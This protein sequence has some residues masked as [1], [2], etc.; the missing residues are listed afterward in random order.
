[1]TTRE[2]ILLSPYRLPTHS[3]LYL[4]DEEVA[5]FLNGYTALWHPAA[6]LGAASPPRVGSP[7][8]YE[9]PAAGHVYAVPDN[10]P[11]MLPDDWEERVRA[12]G[13]RLFRCTTDRAATLANLAE[14]L[15]NPPPAEGEPDPTALLAQPA[16]RVAPF[17]GIGLG[18]AVIEALFEAMSHESVLAASDLWLDVRAAVA[19]LTG[20]DPDAPRRHLQ[21]AADRLLAAREVVYPVTI[22][23]IDLALAEEIGPHTPWPAALAKGQPL[24][25]VACGSFLEKLSREQ[26]GRLNTLREALA[27]EKAELCGGPYL[28]REDPLLPLESQMWNLTKGLAVSRDVAGQD[29]KVFARRRFGFHPQLPQWLQAAGIGRALLVSFDE[30]VLP[31]HRPPVVSWPSPDGKQVDAF[32]RTP[33]PADSPQTWFHLA[34]HLHQTIMQDQAATLALLHRGKPGPPWYEDALEL[35]RF[36]AVLG[37][38]TTLTKYFD[39]V[40]PGEYASAASAD[41]F[42]GEF[43]VERAPATDVSYSEPATPRPAPVPHPISGFAR[44]LRLRR[45]LDTCLTLAAIYRGLART[46]AL[47]DVAALL[48]A[49]EDRLESGDPGAAEELNDSLRKVGEALAG[50]LVARGPENRPGFLLLNPCSF[51]RRVLAELAGVSAPLPVGGPL[52]ACQVENNIVHAVVEVPALGFAWLPGTPAA[53][54]AP[55]PGRMRLADDRCVRNEFFEAEVDP[56]TGGLRSIRDHKTRVGRIGQQLVFNPGSTMRA[57]SLQTT[58]VGPALGEIVSEGALLDP[59]DQVL[60]TFRQRF[61]AWIGRPVLDLR[62]ELFPA[63]APDGYPWHAY[64]AARFAWR[65]ERALLL[66]GVNGSAEVTSHTR[67]QTPDFLEVRWARQNVVLF[68]AG[69]PFHQRHGG[70][71]IDVLLVC[72]GETVQVFELAVGLDR[73]Y[74]MQT[75]LGLVTPA[76]AVAVDRG[77]PHVG[78]EGWLFHLDAPNLLLSALRPAPDAATALTARLLECGGHAMTAELRCVRD[79]GGA[80]LIDARGKTLSELPTHGDAVVLDVARNDLVQVR[81]DFPP[82]GS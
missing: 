46:D 19:S 44:Q 23:L 79:P 8:D 81:I 27:A 9:Q 71:M 77:P 14:A 65:D 12:A 41:E 76:P 73:D 51:K 5:A 24:N 34:Y 52:K 42:H 1:M 25:V 21:S 39:E 61:R 58:S 15:R 62:I 69:L 40:L 55:T 17:F 70:R 63:A 37:R 20:H 6:L 68:P 28:E 78:A 7:Y 35:A 53:G 60:A 11:L 22:H 82:P 2:L 48:S 66:R 72:P 67:P 36:C 33:H 29:V 75:A 18:Y 13:A 16:E 74:P 56:Q 50:R 3:T 59:Q 47:P 54:P 38:W 26:P 49:L 10:P 64:Y 31:A 45:R 43:L 4:G 30:A 32:T 80:A 57:K